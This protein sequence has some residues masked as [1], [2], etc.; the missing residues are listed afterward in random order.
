MVGPTPASKE[1]S[2]AWIDEGWAVPWQ[3]LRDLWKDAPGNMAGLRSPSQASATG[4]LP[5]VTTL[6]D[7]TA[8]STVRPMAPEYLCG[9]VAWGPSVLR[10][11]YPTGG[12]ARNVVAVPCRL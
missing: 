12:F 11:R 7:G 10:T 6:M 4:V 2:S 5:S 9:E 1:L 3:D 8:L